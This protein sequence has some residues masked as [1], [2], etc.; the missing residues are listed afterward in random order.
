MD[1][2]MKLFIG[3]WRLIRP[4]NLLLLAMAPLAMWGSTVLPQAFE[5]DMRPRQVLLLGLAIAL[6]AAGGNIVNDIADREIDR[7][8]GRA[9]PLL[10]FSSVFPAWLLYGISLAASLGITLFLAVQNG[11]YDLALLMPVVSVLLLGYAFSF[12]C[13]AWLGNLLISLLSAGVPA[14]IFAAEPKAW[15]ALVISPYSKMLAGFTLFAFFGTWAREL[16]KDLEDVAGDAAA[17][18]QTLAAQW[19]SEK[20]LLIFRVVLLPALI[21]IAFLAALWWM[22]DNWLMMLGWLVLWLL[23]AVVFMMNY[24]QSEK[25]RD[26]YHV[27]SQMLKIAIVLGF[28]I[29]M[30]KI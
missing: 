16:I 30:I 22:H 15:D 10:H 8:N 4:F 29:L 9:N 25:P 5:P 18:C 14:L 19:Q 20:V 6:V 23:L 13:K 27:A 12:K 2:G 7:L 11:R 21:S 26:R 28:L 1:A 24:E 3:L 17:G